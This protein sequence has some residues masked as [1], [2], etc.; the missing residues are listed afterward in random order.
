MSDVNPSQA[1]SLVG[2]VSF[3]SECILMEMDQV[4]ATRVT[5]NAFTI[6]SSIHSFAV[7]AKKSLGSSSHLGGQEKEETKQ[8][9]VYSDGA[10]I[11]HWRGKSD[12]IEVNLGING[13]LS[14]KNKSCE[15]KQPWGSDPQDKAELCPLFPGGLLWGQAT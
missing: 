4:W 3:I 12:R 9:D 6:H 14:D 5:G 2:Y 15:I 8:A 1:P 13:M 11:Y 10:G 7:V